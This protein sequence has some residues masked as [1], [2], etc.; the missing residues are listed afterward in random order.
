M[1]EHLGDWRDAPVW[2]TDSIRQATESWF[3]HL[4]EKRVGS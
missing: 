4:G 1:L 3:R 2:D